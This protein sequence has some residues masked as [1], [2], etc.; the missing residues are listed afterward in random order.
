MQLDVLL[1]PSHKRIDK[2]DRRGRRRCLEAKRASQLRAGVFHG[3]PLALT[4]SGMGLEQS[5]IGDLL[6][7]RDDVRGGECPAGHGRADRSVPA[8]AGAGDRSPAGGAG[9]LGPR[10]PLQLSTEARGTC[11]HG[12]RHARRHARRQAF[13]EALRIAADTRLALFV[14]PDPST[15]LD[16]ARMLP[17]AAVSTLP[18]PPFTF[19]R[20]GRLDPGDTVTPLSVLATAANEPDFGTDINR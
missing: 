5:R 16:P 2:A 19:Y 17:Y 4:R 12:R 10:Q 7:F 11:L 20:F 8:G 13:L 6:G 1:D 14:Q 9:E 18:E 3:Q 15:R